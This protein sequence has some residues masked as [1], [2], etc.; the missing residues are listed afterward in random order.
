MH[1]VE[2]ST[3]IE[4]WK[5]ALKYI[6][7]KGFDFEDDDKRICREVLNLILTINKPDEYNIIKPVEILNNFNYWK[8]PPLDEIKRVML[9]NKLAPDY[10]YSY[11]PRIFNFQN[12]VNQVNDF[13]I[14]LLKENKTTRRAIVSIFDPVKDSNM[15]SSDTPGLIAIDFKLRNNKLNV[16]AIIRSNDLFFGWPANVYQ[17]FVLQDYIRKQ[18]GVDTGTITTFSVSAHLFRDQLDYVNEILEEN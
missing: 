2:G 13:V 11:G 17:I 16:T 3:P 1:T 8:Y 15:L 7:R 14:P 6:V 5:A 10:A 18:L 4:A 9:G 12:S